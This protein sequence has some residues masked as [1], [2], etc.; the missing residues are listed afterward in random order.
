MRLSALFHDIAKPVVKK[1]IDGKEEPV[2]YN[3]EIVGADITKRIM[4]Q[5][6]FSNEDTNLVVHLVKQ[7]M[8]HYSKEWNDR[9]VRKFINR[10]DKKNLPLLWQL[11]RADRLGSGVKSADC[12]ELMELR[13]RIALVLE[14]DNALKISDLKVNGNIIMKKFHLKPSR[15]LGDILKYLLETSLRTSRKKQKG[16]T[17]S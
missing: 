16:I 5:Y 2:F 15:L 13:N 4:R 11:R 3:H 8:F 10:I 14:K 12:K 17:L 7:H 1:N 9:A 6:K